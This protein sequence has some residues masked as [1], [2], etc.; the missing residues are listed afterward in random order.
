M[1]F[2]ILQLNYN[3]Q[4]VTFARKWLNV[5]QSI[6]RN[7]KG[8]WPPYEC[9]LWGSALLLSVSILWWRFDVLYWLT[10]LSGLFTFLVLR[11]QRF[12]RRL[13]LSAVQQ[14][15]LRL[16]QKQTQTLQELHRGH[17]RRGWGRRR[18]NQG[19]EHLSLFQEEVL[20][21]SPKRGAPVSGQLLHQ[22][23]QPLVRSEE[24]HKRLAHAVQPAAASR[25]HKRRAGYVGFGLGHA[26]WIGIW[27]IVLIHAAKRAAAVE[28]GQ[29]WSRPALQGQDCHLDAWIPCLGGLLGLWGLLHL[30]RC[31]NQGRSDN[32]KATSVY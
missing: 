11:H 25:A 31:L 18:G 28:L 27:V 4:T 29:G 17:P 3:F 2:D 5:E 26:L 19:F 32:Y 6:W 24:A 8:K 30:C 15:A 7:V 14:A 21:H 22:P 10:H 20:N 16:R 9:G 13:Q 12:N 1:S 23:R